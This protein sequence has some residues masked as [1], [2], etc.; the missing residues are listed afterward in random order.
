MFQKAIENVND[1]PNKTEHNLTSVQVR[2]KYIPKVRSVDV[3]GKIVEL[4]RT[5]D[6]LIINQSKWG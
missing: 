5:E 2:P 4:K 6:Q 1:E 3:E